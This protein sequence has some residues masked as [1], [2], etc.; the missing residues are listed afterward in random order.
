MVTFREIWLGLRATALE[1]PSC[2]GSRLTPQH[3]PR[4]PVASALGLLRYR[5]SACYHVVVLKRGLPPPVEGPAEWI[6]DT[7]AP[8]VLA[9]RR[10]SAEE[11]A[12]LDNAVHPA[13]RVN[14]GDITL[15]P[16]E[17]LRDLDVRLAGREQDDEE[18]DGEPG[19]RSAV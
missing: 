9:A 19:R 14:P 18:H 16:D 1:C 12:E 11:L 3:V 4:M 5:C 13:G 2:G 15:R 17:T 8:R 7:E 6:H 10:P